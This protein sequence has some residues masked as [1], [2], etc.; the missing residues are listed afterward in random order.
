MDLYN[1]A[2]NLMIIS[3]TYIALAYTK[4]KVRNFVQALS[5]IYTHAFLFPIVTKSFIKSRDKTP[6]PQMAQRLDPWSNFIQ[7][8]LY[9]PINFQIRQVIYSLT[10]PI[11]G[12]LLRLQSGFLGIVWNCMGIMSTICIFGLGIPYS[13]SSSIALW[14]LESS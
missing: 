1:H 12:K 7:S 5:T 6:T 8:F 14:S 3:Y 2:Y 11:H 13:N 9:P 10:C 4:H